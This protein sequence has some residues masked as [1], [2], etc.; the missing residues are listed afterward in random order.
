MVVEQALCFTLRDYDIQ[1]E[2]LH[3]GI[4]TEGERS[5]MAEDASATFEHGLRRRVMGTTRG[6]FLR[7]SLSISSMISTPFDK[8][9]TWCPSMRPILELLQYALHK[10]TQKLKVMKFEFGLIVRIQ[11]LLWVPEILDRRKCV[12]LWGATLPSLLHRGRG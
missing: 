8:E 2:G 7:N 10:I 3:G 1:H 6:I 4:S 9:I 11:L 12:G 5:S